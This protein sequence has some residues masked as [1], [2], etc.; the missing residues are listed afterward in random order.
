VTSRYEKVSRK[1]TPDGETGA[2]NVA[3]AVADR[4]VEATSDR[5]PISYH[6]AANG[7]ALKLRKET[8]P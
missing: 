4:R 7:A 5:L 2:H 8:L 6:K 3:A 1:F